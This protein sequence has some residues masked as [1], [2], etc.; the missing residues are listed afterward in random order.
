MDYTARWRVFLN[1]VSKVPKNLKS[2]LESA[3]VQS[4]FWTLPNGVNDSDETAEGSRIIGTP[5][6][7]ALAT[8][9]NQAAADAQADLYFEVTSGDDAYALGPEDPRYP[10]NWMMRG[11]YR[12]PYE[13]QDGRHAVW[14]EIRTLDE[15]FNFD[16]FDP[17]ALASTISTTINHE[18]VHYYQL[19][20]QAK[21]KNLSDSEAYK[22][23]VCDPKQT[24]VGDPDEYREVCGK[25]P[26][27][28]KDDRE[29]YLSRHVEID[30]FA[31]EAAEKLLLKHKDPQN[32]ADE[33]RNLQLANI[34]D[35]PELVDVLADYSYEF[36]KNPQL[37]NKFRKKVYTQ[38]MTQVEEA[39]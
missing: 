23:M 36:K 15:D 1:E 8:S 9:L 32:A 37:L 22:E 39:E 5:A 30:A 17:S 38:I 11:Q 25:E 35:Y 12:G 34:D 3:I 33:I 4:K 7:E 29:T 26:P 2:S 24:P 16:E 28:Q 13:E 19:K 21:S 31:Y 20:K 14:L 10:N 18:L 27:E 6:T